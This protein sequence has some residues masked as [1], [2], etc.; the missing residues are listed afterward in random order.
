M[1]ECSHAV[2]V[3]AATIKE[4][5]QVSSFL[6]IDPVSV[7]SG[8]NRLTTYV[9]LDSGSTVAFIDELEFLCKF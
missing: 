7:Q 3:S 6:Q 5:N 2:N 4:N 8:G 1:D 9:F